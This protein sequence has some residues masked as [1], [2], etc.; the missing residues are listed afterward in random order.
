M[1]LEE[2]ACPKSI[3]EDTAIWPDNRVFRDT[4]FRWSGDRISYFKW[5]ANLKYYQYESIKMSQ[6]SLSSCHLF[7]NLICIC[8]KKHR[9]VLF[10]SAR[11]GI[12]K[13]SN[14]VQGISWNVILIQVI[15]FKYLIPYYELF[16]SEDDWDMCKSA[17]H[18][19]KAICVTMY[20]LF[21]KTFCK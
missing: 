21:Y 17:I 6:M 15:Y 16:R 2:N 4:R 11:F 12:A 19:T 7:L 13:N 14:D 20:S 9:K 8:R 1:D 5:L 18:L 3:H 10:W